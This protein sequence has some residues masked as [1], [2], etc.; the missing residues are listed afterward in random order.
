MNAVDTNV[1]ICM[2]DPRD[3]RKQCVAVDLVAHWVKA[4]SEV[5]DRF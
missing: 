5:E 2:H 1:F 3:L 4:I